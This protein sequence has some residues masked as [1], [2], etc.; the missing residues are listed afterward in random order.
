MDALKAEWRLV[1]PPIQHTLKAA[2]DRRHKAVAQ[3][4][5]EAVR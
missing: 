1:P 5:A 2:L 3:K 4:A